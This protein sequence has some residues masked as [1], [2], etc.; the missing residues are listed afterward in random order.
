MHSSNPI[1]HAQPN[2]DA[3]TDENYVTSRTV[4]TLRPPLGLAKLELQQQKTNKQNDKQRK[5]PMNYA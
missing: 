4:G 5:I 2:T 3:E 1:N